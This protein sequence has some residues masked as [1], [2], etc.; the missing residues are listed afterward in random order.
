ME[1]FTLFVVEDGP[2]HDGSEVALASCSLRCLTSASSFFIVTVGSWLA[3]ACTSTVI[4]F[5]SLAN[6]RELRLV[7][8]CAAAGL[9]VTMTCTRELPRSAL[10]NNSVNLEFRKRAMRFTCPLPFFS[11]AIECT[12]DCNHMRLLLMKLSSTM[13]SPVT[14]VVFSF[15]CPA[16]SAKYTSEVK[17]TPSFWSCWTTSLKTVWPR[18]LCEFMAVAAIC[19][20]SFP[21]SIKFIHSSTE[22]IVFSSAPSTLTPLDSTCSCTLFFEPGEICLCI[23]LGDAFLPF[24]GDFG[25]LTSSST[26]KSK[27]FSL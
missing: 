8:K 12:A 5:T 25:L 1:Q 2:V 11:C 17:C 26:S 10:D 7:P 27:I 23:F 18:E 19:F 24:S 15:S 13:R 14:F 21:S 9:S 4:C 20:R 22:L 6:L 3:A 16:K